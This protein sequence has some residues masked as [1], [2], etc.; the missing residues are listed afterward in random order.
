LF[1]L[2]VVVGVYFSN[3]NAPDAQ[4]PEH[5]FQAKPNTTNAI[6]IVGLMFRLNQ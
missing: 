5:P 4:T 1:D 6:G 2:L 3:V